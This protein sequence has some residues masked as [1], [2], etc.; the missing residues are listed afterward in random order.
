MWIDVD[1]PNKKPV[2]IRLAKGLHSP[3]RLLRPPGAPG[4]WEPGLLLLHGS[5]PPRLHPLVPRRRE[6]DRLCRPAAWCEGQRRSL[7]HLQL[8]AKWEREPE[9]DICLLAVVRFLSLPRVQAIH[10]KR[11]KRARCGR[12]PESQ[13]HSCVDHDSNGYKGIFH[14]LMWQYWYCN[15]HFEQCQIPSLVCRICI[16]IS[17]RGCMMP[18]GLKNVKGL[19]L[20]CIAGL[21]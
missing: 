6:R 18:L 12:P 21:P 15:S 7:Q 4:E 8:F 14:R 16:Q 1:S 2:V 11:A 5:L 10:P 17:V 20:S 9:P 19:N 13:S 3:R